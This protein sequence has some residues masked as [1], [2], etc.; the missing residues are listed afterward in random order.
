MSVHEAM[1]AGQLANAEAELRRLR[2]L[3]RRA[4][5]AE[6]CDARPEI[7]PGPCTCWKAKA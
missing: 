6:H 5:H 4:P 2:E 3:I 1:L 7:F